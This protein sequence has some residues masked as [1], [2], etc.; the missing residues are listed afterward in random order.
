MPLQFVSPPDVLTALGKVRIWA[1]SW[2]CTY[3]EFSPAVSVCLPWPGAGPQ[4]VWE[5]QSILWELL[6]IHLLALQRGKLRNHP[7]STDYGNLM[8]TELPEP[9]RSQPRQL[10][11]VNSSG[12]T[13]QYIEYIQHQTALPEW[14]V[15]LSLSAQLHCYPGTTKVK[16]SQQLHARIVFSKEVSLRN[17][18]IECCYLLCKLGWIYLRLIHNRGHSEKGISDTQW[19]GSTSSCDCI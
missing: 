17:K 6:F 13:M 10:L 5:A 3:R 16:K 12:E 14:P 18:A 9:H 15:E 11:Q 4:V 7:L 1:V 19:S 2:H 8:G